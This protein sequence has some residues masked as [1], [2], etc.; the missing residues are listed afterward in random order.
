MSDARSFGRAIRGEWLLE[1]GMS[2]LNHGSFGAT[3]RRVLAA[4]ARWRRAMER[5]PL[6]HFLDEVPSALRTAAEEL[7]ALIGASADDLAFVENATGACNAVLQ[8]YRLGPGDEV[9]GLGHIYPAIANTIEHVCRRSGARATLL[10]LSF[11]PRDPDEGVR[12]LDGAIGPATKL[13]VVDHITSTT[14]LIEPVERLVALCRERGVPVLVDGAHAPGM[15]P[16]D[17]DALGADHYAGN[18]HK[19]LCSAKGCAFLWSRPD[20]VLPREELHPAVISLF[21]PAGFPEEFGWVGTRDCS[22]WLS[23]PEAIA[24]HRELGPARI[25]AH[26]HALVREA[27]QLLC[28]AWGVVDVI[29]EELVGSMLTLPSPVQ[30]EPTMEG[31]MGLRARLWQEHRVEVMPVTIEGRTWIRISA[32]VYNELDDYRRLAEALTC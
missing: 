6:R 27:G 16:L 9:I 4:Q 8:S 30:V 17:L 3:P 32:Q 26:N 23:L 1:E 15:V 21:H 5:Q 25:R 10:T 13:V 14:A 2:F 19:W 22:A 29:P 20:A 12:L 24:M 18:C 31:G 28:D 11:P 7:G